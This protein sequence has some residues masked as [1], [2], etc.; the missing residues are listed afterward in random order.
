MSIDWTVG[1]RVVHQSIL[2]RQTGSNHSHSILSCFELI[3]A[4]F[5]SKY[6]YSVPLYTS[7]W[8]LNTLSNRIA[9]FLL[10]SFPLRHHHHHHLHLSQRQGMAISR[11]KAYNLGVID[12]SYTL[13]LK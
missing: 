2:Q 9:G 12:L 5:D 8:L 6:G 3:L 7:L 13:N 4:W 10:N 1:Q 11:V